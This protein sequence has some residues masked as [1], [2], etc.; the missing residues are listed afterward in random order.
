MARSSA[1]PWALAEADADLA[2][3]ADSWPGLEAQVAAIADDIAYDNHDIDDGL[4]AGL[5]TLEE[6][7]AVPLVARG[8]GGGARAPSG[9]RRGAA[10]PRAG[11]R[12]D[13]R[14]WSTTSSTRRAA[15]SRK[16]ASS[17]S[18]TSAPPAAR[19]PAS[20]PAMAAEERALKALPPRPHV[21]RAVG[22][23]GPRRG[24]ARCSPLC[25]TPIAPI[26]ACSRPNGAGRPT[27]PAR[28]APSATSS[29]A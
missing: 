28:S 17:R 23:G 25:S 22:A 6:L 1:P 12:P 18:T 2:A 13:R 10:G 5:F 9:R 14:A 27:K 21:R 29:P 7:L 20:P 11:P 16:P 4:R 26:R 24:P 3:R 15:A 19:S 8:L